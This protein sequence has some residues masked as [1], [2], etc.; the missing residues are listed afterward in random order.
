LKARRGFIRYDTTYIDPNYSWDD[1][2]LTLL[3][4]WAH[5]LLYTKCRPLRFTL[6]E[7]RERQAHAV[8]CM[9]GSHMGY[10]FQYDHPPPE[11]ILLISEAAVFMIEEIRKFL[12]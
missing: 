5:D 12:E 10:E 9:V 7:E 4:E 11:N 3:H 6:G 8:A 2:L 1:M